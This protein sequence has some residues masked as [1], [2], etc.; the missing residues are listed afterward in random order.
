MEMLNFITAIPET[1]GKFVMASILF[2]DQRTVRISSPFKIFCLYDN[3]ATQYEA[4]ASDLEGTACLEE[5]CMAALRESCDSVRQ[6]SIAHRNKNKKVA[7][8]SSSQKSRKT[9]G[10]ILETVRN[11]N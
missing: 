5:N 10:V 9:R 3:S 6:S 2:Q 8:R 11:G 7:W 4:R 1:N